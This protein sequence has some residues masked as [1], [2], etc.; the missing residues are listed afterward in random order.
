MTSVHGCPATEHRATEHRDY[1][2][3]R[4]GVTWHGPKSCW[5]CGDQDT[6]IVAAHVVHR[7]VWRPSDGA[8]AGGQVVRYYPGEAP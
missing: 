5:M 3:L 6:F 7:T 4:C 8:P 2:C 1:G